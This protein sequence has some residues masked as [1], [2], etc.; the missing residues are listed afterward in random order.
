[1]DIEELPVIDISSGFYLGCIM[2]IQE[3]HTC[4]LPIYDSNRWA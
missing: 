1:M 3:T 4:S 2:N